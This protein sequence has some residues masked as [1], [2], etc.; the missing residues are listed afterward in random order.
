VPTTN[1]LVLYEMKPSTG[2]VPASGFP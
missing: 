2:F 1:A